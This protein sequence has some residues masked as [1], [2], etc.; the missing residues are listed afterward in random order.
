MRDA[1]TLVAGA[2]LARPAVHFSD[3]HDT[4]TVRS[5]L[6][7]L[8]AAAS[9]IVIGAAGRNLLARPEQL[10]A[11]AAHALYSRQLQDGSRHS[12]AEHKHHQRSAVGMHGIHSLMREWG[13]GHRNMEV[14]RFILRTGG[15]ARDPRLNP[16]D[17]E[18]IVDI[19]LGND[20]KETGSAV[21]N[22]FIVIAFEPMPE[23]MRSIRRALGKLSTANSKRID[24]I[25][26]QRGADGRWTMPPLAK[27][28][29]G[30]GHAYVIRAAVGDTDSTLMLPNAN[31]GGVTGSVTGSNNNSAASSSL[32][33]TPQV[34]LDTVLRQLPW[35]T[36]VRML[37]MDTQGYELKVLHG[38]MESLQGGL[39]TYVQYE[40]SPWLM[41]RGGLGDPLMLLQLLPKLGAICFDMMGDHNLFPRPGAPFASYHAQL[42]SGNR[43]RKVLSGRGTIQINGPFEDILCWFPFATERVAPLVD[44]LNDRPCVQA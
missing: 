25:D 37:K 10:P 26:M 1:P 2:S 23:N 36:H 44:H 14:P 22:G 28:Q 20:A 40:L 16:S 42:N 32:V 38:A 43:S 18:V 7:L 33:P 21:L 13:C 5:Y 41:T 15:A 39:F 9:G 19:G 27:P 4:R 8:V 31:T 34:K 11:A 35:V 3:M 17:R 12:D 6:A 24:F 30:H 29:A